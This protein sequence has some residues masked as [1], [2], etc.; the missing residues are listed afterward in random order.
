[1]QLGNLQGDIF[2]DTYNG[3]GK[4]SGTLLHVTGKTSERYLQGHIQCN[5]ENFI[6]LSSRTHA[7]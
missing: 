4:T 7:M 5:W 2:R 3:I 6:E 1:M